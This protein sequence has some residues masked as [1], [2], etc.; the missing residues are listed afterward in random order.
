MKPLTLTLQNFGPYAGPEVSVDFARLDRLF[1]IGGDTGSG[2]TSIFDALSYSIYGVPLGTRSEDS[3]R[4]QFAADDESTLVTFRFETLT[5]EYQVTRSPY[6][7]E[8]RARG[9]GLKKASDHLTVLRRPLSGGDWAKV[10]KD[11]HS[12]G[13]DAVLEEAIGFSHAEFS[14][15]VVLPQGQFQQFLEMESSKR[16]ALL[17]LLFPVEIHERVAALSKERSEA[18]AEAG[19][20]LSSRMAEV[21]KTYDPDTAAAVLLELETRKSVTGELADSAEEHLEAVTR[22]LTEGR[23]QAEQFRDLALQKDRLQEL[24]NQSDSMDMLRAQQAEHVRALTVRSPLDQLDTIERNIA[25]TERELVGLNLLLEEAADRDREAKAAA[26]DLQ[27]ERVTLQEQRDQLQIL[28]NRK[29]HLADLLSLDLEIQGLEKAQVAILGSYEKAQGVH[30]GFL[31]ALS[32][33]DSLEEQAS[34]LRTERDALLEQLKPLSLLKKDSERWIHIRDLDLPQATAARNTAEGKVQ[35]AELKLKVAEVAL[36]LSV[37]ARDRS[38]AASL[39]ERLRP[40]QPCPVCGSSEHPAPASFQDE[41]EAELLAARQE[42]VGTAGQSVQDAKELRGIKSQALAQKESE[43]QRLQEALGTAG[44]SDPESLL[45]RLK[46]LNDAATERSDRL[47]GLD[48]SLAERPRLSEDLKTASAS[49]SECQQKVGD[50]QS[51]LDKKRGGRAQVAIAAGAPEDPTSASMALDVQV[52]AETQAV[53]QEAAR[54]DRLEKEAREAREGLGALEAAIGQ[55]KKGRSGQETQRT[56]FKTA[57]AIAL[58]AS[59]FP[60][61]ETARKALLSEEESSA[62]KDSLKTYDHDL[63]KTRGGISA[64]EN[65][66]AGK[67]L[68]DL[69]C[70]SAKEAE[71]REKRDGARSDY[72]RAQADLQSHSASAGR[73]MQLQKEEAALRDKGA[74]FIELSNDL[75]GLGGEGRPKLG[76][77]SFVLGRWLR[78]VLEQG[79]TRLSTLSGGRYRFIYSDATSD[80]RKKSGLDIDVHDAHAGGVRG[81]RSLSGGEKFLASLSLALGLSDVIQAASGGRRLDALFIDEG[82]GS[83]DGESLDRAIGVLEEVGEGRQVGIISHVESLKKTITSQIQVVKGPAGSSLSIH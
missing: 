56:E 27:T 14:K 2:K 17:K 44:Y 66:L 81:V 13:P 11:S 47:K 34:S 33:L 64:L 18:F 30:A 3:V 37:E 1:L 74:I 55:A 58:A 70:L 54:L 45:A 76:F 46:E 40:G 61:G 63:G 4:S 38:Q 7:I 42:L 39:S 77:S 82:F 72:Q 67:E 53:Q 43:T 73:W 51:E 57:L 59:G 79:S 29:A 9:A 36:Q 68:P 62:M 15:L 80:K 69:P 31:E 12:E 71:A 32:A 83:L 78:Q 60:D 65:S 19:K 24:L 22:A 20:D 75:N 10:T 8:K 26:Q 25:Q 49:L 6:W 21:R 48:L 16:E 35:E 41:P 5:E 52:K 50:S 23:L 28:Q